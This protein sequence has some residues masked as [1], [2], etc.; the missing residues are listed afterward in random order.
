MPHSL[1]SKKVQIMGANFSKWLVD[2]T[3]TLDA[4]C[5]ESVFTAAPVRLSPNRPSHSVRHIRESQ[6]H[7]LKVDERTEPTLLP[8]IIHPAR[9]SLSLSLSNAVQFPSKPNTT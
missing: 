8:V 2:I 7:F 3:T 4:V 9:Q 1:L 6:L 5:M